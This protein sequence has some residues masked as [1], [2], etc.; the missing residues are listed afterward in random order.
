MRLDIVG[1]IR[2]STPS[3]KVRSILAYIL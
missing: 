1:D 3:W 2:L